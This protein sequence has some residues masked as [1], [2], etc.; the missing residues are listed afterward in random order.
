MK[1]FLDPERVIE[2]INQEAWH[3]SKTYAKEAYAESITYE[4][5][6]NK[7]LARRRAALKYLKASDVPSMYLGKTWIVNG[8]QIFTDKRSAFIFSEGHHICRFRRRHK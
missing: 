2:L 4:C 1:Q 7:E 8:D 5:G 6:G 3:K